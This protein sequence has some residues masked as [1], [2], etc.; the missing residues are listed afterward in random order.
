MDTPVSTSD[1]PAPPGAIRRKTAI[2]ACAAQLQKNEHVLWQGRGSGR[3]LS[4]LNRALLIRLGLLAMGAVLLII[5]MLDNRNPAYNWVAWLLVA[6]LIGRVALFVWQSSATPSRQVAM[7]T[8]HRLVSIDMLRPMT[9]WKIDLHGE[10]RADGKHFAPHP[11]I[12]TGTKERGHIRL[13]TAPQNRRAYPPFILFNVERPLELAETHQEDAEHRPPDQGPDEVTARPIWS[14]ASAAR[15]TLLWSATASADLRSADL[16]RQ[17]PDLRRGRRG[18]AARRR[19]ACGALCGI[20][21]PTSR[22]AVHAGRIH[23]ALH[24]LRPRHVRALALGLPPHVRAR[25]RRD[26][27]C[28][29]PP[30]ASSPSTRPAADR[31]RNARRRDRR[32]HRLRPPQDAGRLRPPQGR[33]EGRPRLRHRTHRPPDRSQ[34]VHRGHV[35]PGPPDIGEASRHDRP[36][37]RPRPAHA[38]ARPLH[39]RLPRRRLQRARPPVARRRAADQHQDLPRHHARHR[40]RHGLR[41]RR[42]PRRAFRLLLASPP[43]SSRSPPSGGRSK[44][45][46]CSPSATC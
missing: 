17:P 28:A 35:H 10:G 2:R 13:N 12:V 36:P 19:A 23:A 38:E 25:S 14:P 1:T 32:R 24:R 40:R 15:R 6:L 42:L 4:A 7:L 20:A 16:S 45:S 8:T 27:L 41:R 11:I 21:R 43:A 34:V 26:P 18:L 29:A 39:R 46:A 22:P 5:L 30:R 37:R 9:N 44:A 33:P 3:A 31:R